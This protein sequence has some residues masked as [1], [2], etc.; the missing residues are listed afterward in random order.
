[1]L[2]WS[3]S[4]EMYLELSDKQRLSIGRK[5]HDI[6]FKEIL[7]LSEDEMVA[8]YLYLM[9]MAPFMSLNEE[10][11]VKEYYFFKDATGYKETYKRFLEIANKGKSE[12]I[13]QFLQTYFQKL[14]GEV[15]TAYLS[16]GLAL[17]TIKGEVTPK[18][19]EIFER[20]HG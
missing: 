14:G 10:F 15:L 8:P 2:D 7:N 6:L 4:F 16:F 17:I 11:G 20:L 1:M 12:K 18:D 5:C 3:K 9:S 13:G 19:K